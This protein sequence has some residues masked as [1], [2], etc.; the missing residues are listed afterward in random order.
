MN[1]KIHFIKNRRSKISKPNTPI[2]KLFRQRPKEAIKTIIY[3]NN[4]NTPTPPQDDIKGIFADKETG[5]LLLPFAP[6]AQFYP[7]FPDDPFNVPMPNIDQIK[8]IISKMKEHSAGPDGIR[9]SDIK[10]IDVSDDILQL[11]SEV[12]TVGQVPISWKKSATTMIP[13]NGKTNS[14]L[15]LP[16]AWRPITKSNS[17]P[18]LAASFLVFYFSFW[19]S[20]KNIISSH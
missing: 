12:F 11:L 4:G 2:H 10:K 6:L 18:K 14:E 16:N 7:S 1:G 17:I 20:D 13:K 19:I 5:A 15:L 8:G 3:S 9:P